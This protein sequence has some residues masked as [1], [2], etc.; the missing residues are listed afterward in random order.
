MWGQSAFSISELPLQSFHRSAQGCV[1]RFDAAD[2]RDNKVDRA[3][4]NGVSLN[5][6]SGANGPVP[7]SCI[8]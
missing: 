3:D 1:G 6:I 7:P 2:G 8:N 5:C 4:F